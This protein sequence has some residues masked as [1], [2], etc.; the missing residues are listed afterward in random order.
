MISIVDVGPFQCRWIE[1]DDHMCCG[2]QA[3]KGSWCPEHRA[4]VFKTE[5]PIQQ[6]RQAAE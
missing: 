6:Y 5:I 1:G 2:K 3:L 4:I